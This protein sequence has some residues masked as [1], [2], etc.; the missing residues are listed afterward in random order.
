MA[1]IGLTDLTNV[2]KCSLRLPACVII[3]KYPT[4]VYNQTHK[5]ACYR[6]DS[7]LL[8]YSDVSLQY[9]L[10]S[11]VLCRCQESEGVGMYPS[12]SQKARRPD[13]K[14]SLAMSS[15]T[16]KLNHPSS[17]QLCFN[18][19]SEALT[20]L[21]VIEAKRQ[22]KNALTPVTLQYLSSHQNYSL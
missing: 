10:F 13:V 4:N 12:V 15:C 5:V 6:E 18:I 21:P 9:V 2:K 19:S 8:V 7:Y 1:I 11:S 20:T 14:L 22:I 3:M 17:L 16:I